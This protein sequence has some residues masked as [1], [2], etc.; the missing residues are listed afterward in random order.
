[1]VPEQKRQ[2]NIDGIQSELLKLDGVKSA[3]V[4]ENYE[5]TTNSKG[6]EGKSI[7]AIV[8]GGRDEDIA[9]A[10][11]KKKDQAIKTIGDTCKTIKDN[12]GNERK[13]CFYRPKKKGVK[14]K[15]SFTVAQG[16]NILEDNLLGIVKEYI[17]N[18]KVG[19]YITSYKCESEDIRLVY[20]ADKLLNIDISFK[21]SET[22]GEQYEKVLKL[23]FNEVAEY[24]Q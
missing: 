14:V 16:E 8:D 11:W 3:M 18:V 4:D 23:A 21:F 2:W 10:I 13:I 19:E 6:L 17:K 12:Q 20:P 15:I 1:M 9:L 24:E 5:M 22:A 7:V